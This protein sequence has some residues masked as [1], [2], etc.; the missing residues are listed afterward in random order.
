LTDSSED[1]IGVEK[2]ITR[3]PKKLF[4]ISSDDNEEEAAPTPPKPKPRRRLQKKSV[5]VTSPIAAEIEAIDAVYLNEQVVVTSE[6]EV[7]DLTES[8]P[9]PTYL[10]SS[11]FNDCSLDKLIEFG[12]NDVLMA[13]IS[14]LRPFANDDDVEEKLS[15]EKK[16]TRVRNNLYEMTEDL[17]IVDSMISRVEQLGKLLASSNIGMKQPV[18]FGGEKGEFTLKNYQIF[19][20]GWLVSLY[21]ELEIGGILADE[22]VLLPRSNR[23]R[24]WERLVQLLDFYVI[25]LIS[26]IN[27]NI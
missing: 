10:L 14:S 26:R 13:V 5:I 15:N 22:M 16:Y 12:G 4:I 3:T 9:V 2:K 11:F 19:G 21:K 7:V 17:T 8:E 23:S 1:E 6:A 20:V 27:Q 18:S 25:S 24:D